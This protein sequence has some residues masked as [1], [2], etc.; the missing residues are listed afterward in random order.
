M[1]KQLYVI[2]IQLVLLIFT[3]CLLARP[4]CLLFTHS[5][6]SGGNANCCSAAGLI[7]QRLS[8]SRLADRRAPDNA[9][10]TLNETKIILTAQSLP[11]RESCAKLHSLKQTEQDNRN[12]LLNTDSWKSQPCR[13]ANSSRQHF[14]NYPCVQ[15]HIYAAHQTSFK[16]C[17]VK[18][19]VTRISTP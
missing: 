14:N 6:L 16:I 12:T 2:A 10:E 17:R 9:M 15:L 19:R 7:A 1:Y 4:L 13:T 18:F 8:D 3:A 11:N 5:L